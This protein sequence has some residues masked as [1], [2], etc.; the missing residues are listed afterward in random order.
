MNVVPM[1]YSTTETPTDVTR[2]FLFEKTVSLEDLVAG[3]MEL[4]R[5]EGLTISYIRLI[6]GSV[7]TASISTEVD[8][9]N[10]VGLIRSCLAD[11]VEVGAYLD[12]VFV[13]LELDLPYKTIML[14]VKKEHEWLVDAVIEGGWHTN[15]PQGE[16]EPC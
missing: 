4:A 5:A 10:L 1:R 6:N 12:D 2:R 9:E 16:E 15:D 8:D 7:G 14:T 13:Y 3:F 11:M